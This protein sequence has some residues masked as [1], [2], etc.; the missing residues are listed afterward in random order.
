M[1]PPIPRFLRDASSEMPFRQTAASF[2]TKTQGL[3]TA[4]TNLTKEEDIPKA[5][6]RG[7]VPFHE[8]KELACGSYLHYRYAFF[9]RD[10]RSQAKGS[11]TPPLPKLSPIWHENEIPNENK[12]STN[13]LRSRAV[14]LPLE[15]RPP[16]NHAICKMSRKS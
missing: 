13:T 11:G 4:G 10:F 12:S 3:F 7:R 9:I 2:K 8:E 1:D 15:M 6:V 16:Q 14:Q 5:E